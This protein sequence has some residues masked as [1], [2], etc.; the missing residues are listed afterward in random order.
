MKVEKQL[1]CFSCF[2]P[3]RNNCFR[4]IAITSNIREKSVLPANVLC[5]FISNNDS[6]LVNILEIKKISNTGSPYFLP[7]FQVLLIW[8]Q[9]KAEANK[10]SWNC[11]QLPI[12]HRPLLLVFKIGVKTPWHQACGPSRAIHIGRHQGNVPWESRNEESTSSQRCYRAAGRL[13]WYMF[14]QAK[15]K[16]S[17]TRKEEEHFKK[18]C[19]QV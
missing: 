13:Y 10:F 6:L 16:P 11:L 7:N 14:L 17:S 3:I 8:F 19:Q 1:F 2:F 9:K 12:W 18:S 5:P 4:I 15:C